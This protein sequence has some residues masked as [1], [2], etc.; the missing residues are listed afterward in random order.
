MGY[1]TCE[2]TELLYVQIVFSSTNKCAFEHE[3]LSLFKQSRLKAR[4]S[5]NA[6]NPFNLK[7]LS[8]QKGVPYGSKNCI[9]NLLWN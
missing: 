1:F 3:T 6:V 7:N 4:Q 5:V 8:V 9:S 2:I